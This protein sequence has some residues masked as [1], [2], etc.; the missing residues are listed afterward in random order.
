M[1]ASEQAERV[2]KNTLLIFKHLSFALGGGKADKFS[3]LL[4]RWTVA[5]VA[6]AQL[7]FNGSAQVPSAW[8]QAFS[9]S[10]YACNYI[11]NKVKTSEEAKH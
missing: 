2:R 4:S 11:N 1:A 10:S 5:G 3:I 9:S 7:Q 6:S 8:A